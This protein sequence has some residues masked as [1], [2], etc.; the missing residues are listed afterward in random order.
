[1]TDG[2]YRANPSVLLDPASTTPFQFQRK[3][4][5]LVGTRC[6]LRIG[7]IWRGQK[8]G[9]QPDYEFETF[10]NVWIDETTTTLVKAA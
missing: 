6:I 8:L 4:W 7:D 9:F 3:V 2:D 5:V 1:V 10:Q